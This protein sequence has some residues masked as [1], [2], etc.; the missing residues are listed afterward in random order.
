MNPIRPPDDH[1]PPARQT[2]RREERDDARWE[3]RQRTRAATPG[4]YGDCY[5]TPGCEHLGPHRGDHAHHV[6]QRATHGS[7]DVDGLYLCAIGHRWAH[8]NIA[9]A[10][11]LGLIIRGS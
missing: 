8:D 7:D 3:F 1:D 2:A 5:G 11:R 10:T 4:G 9:E 6:G